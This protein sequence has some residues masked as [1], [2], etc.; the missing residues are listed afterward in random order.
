M[1]ENVIFCFSG[2]GNCLDIA[3]NIA[4]ELG[5]TDVVMM[6]RAPE[7]TDVRGAGRVGFVFPCYGGGLPGGVE[8]SIRSVRLDPAAYTFAVCSCAAYPGTGLSIVNGIYPLD[9][10]AVISHQ[11]SCIWLFPHTMMLPPLG[12]DA[13]Q[14][15]AER[16]AKR[17]GRCVKARVKREKKPKA[18]GQRRRE[19][20]VRRDDGAEGEEV[21]R[22]R[23]LHRLRH[24]R[25]GLPQRQHPPRGR[26]AAVR[27]GLP[28][29]PR[30]P[31][32]LSAGGDFPRRGHAQARALP[33]PQRYGGRFGERRYSH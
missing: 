12:A 9:Y 22:R 27:N 8:A 5:D 26:Q 4:R 21:R 10:W 11:C 23:A 15:R 25:E 20:G 7:I 32:I 14:N 19:Q 24:L 16:E 33:Q 6:R 3:R 28:A 30:L 2:T 1:S 31:A 29:M 17:V 13:A 18:P